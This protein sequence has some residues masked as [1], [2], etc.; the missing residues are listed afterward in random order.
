MCYKRRKQLSMKVTSGKQKSNKDLQVNYCV[1]KR[2]LCS[3]LCVI[4][5]ED[6]HR[7]LQPVRGSWPVCMV[8]IPI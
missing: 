7:E 3:L 5:N 2:L 8:Y 1:V 6:P 4:Q